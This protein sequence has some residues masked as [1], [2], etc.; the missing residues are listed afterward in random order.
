MI[1]VK[2]IFPVCSFTRKCCADPVLDTGRDE[3][4]R[5]RRL[6]FLADHQ[7][8]IGTASLSWGAE[9][10]YFVERHL[11]E[12]QMRG[13]WSDIA[14][15]PANDLG[16]NVPDDPWAVNTRLAAQAHAYVV[17][18]DRFVC[19]KR[20]RYSLQRPGWVRKRA[21]EAAWAIIATDFVRTWPGGLPPAP[22]TG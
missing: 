2:E 17:R 3:A 16:R 4:D 19:Q 14:R 21:S 9:L 11:I 20:R 8:D 12:R 7:Q 13:K 5:L 15:L 18:E 10:L 6:G 1:P 22:R